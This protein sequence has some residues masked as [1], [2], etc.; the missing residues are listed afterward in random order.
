[1]PVEIRRRRDEL[2]LSIAA[3]RDQKD[4]LNEDEYYAK[5]EKLMVDL[6]RLYRELGTAVPAKVGAAHSH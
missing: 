1:M 4:K 6:A 5:L 3:L 2:E